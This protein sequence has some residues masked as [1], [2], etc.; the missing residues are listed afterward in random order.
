MNCRELNP[1]ST[2]FRV[3]TATRPAMWE[4]NN[5]LNYVPNTLSLRTLFLLIFLDLW[6]CAEEVHE[7]GPVQVLA[8]LVERKPVPARAVLNVGADVPYVII[9]LEVPRKHLGRWQ[10]SKQNN[11]KNLRRVTPAGPLCTIPVHSEVEHVEPEPDWSHLDHPEDQSGETQKDEDQ[12]PPPDHQ[13]HLV[14]DDV[15]GQ[16][17]DGVYVLLFP[18]GTISIDKKVISYKLLSPKFSTWYYVDFHLTC[19]S[20]RRQFL[21]KCSTLDLWLCPV[22]SPLVEPGN[23]ARRWSRSRGSGCSRSCRWRTWRWRQQGSWGTHRRWSHSSRCCIC[24]GCWHGRTKSIYKCVEV[25]GD[26]ICIT[27]AHLN[28]FIP[29][30]FWILNDPAGGALAKKLHESTFHDQP[31]TPWHVEVNRQHDQVDWH[32]LVVGVVDDTWKL[33]IQMYSIFIPRIQF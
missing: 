12:E 20:C 8:Q 14:I 27:L 11:K 25:M 15:Q 18:T 16:D 1:V 2:A 13:E 3:N 24:C 26:H 5:I 19:S 22:F 29:F 4:A 30:L 7:E 32:P 10:F 17:A 9:P 31:E 33:D 23:I 21:G 28:Q 6:Q